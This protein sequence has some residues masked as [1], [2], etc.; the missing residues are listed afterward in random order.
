MSMHFPPAV[1]PDGS[2]DRR[3]K[4]VVLGMDGV[5]GK[6]SLCRRLLTGKFA[7]P[8][9]PDSCWDPSNPGYRPCGAEEPADV[10]VENSGGEHHPDSQPWTVKLCDTA[11]G[12]DYWKL[13]PTTVYPGTHC[14]ILCFS[15]Q[16]RYDSLK[17]VMREGPTPSE[18]RG[19]SCGWASEVRHLYPASRGFKIPLILV[20]TKLDL[21]EAAAAA[22]ASSQRSSHTVGCCGAPPSD[23]APD[24]VTH[25]EGLVAS[26]RLGA[27]QYV[28]VS[29]LTKQGLPELLGHVV[30]LCAA[31]PA[32]HMHL[33]GRA[34][35]PVWTEAEGDQFFAP[36]AAVGGKKR[37]AEQ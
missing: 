11:G 10:V 9:D 17:S 15:L 35:L 21:R 3:L 12:E 33:R 5:A 4:C 13:R 26:K 32:D 20:G 14:F 18:K 34:N 31:P 25:E 23:N 2:Q 30:R 19:R 27:A 1:G 6:S 24:F 7:D 37:C 22:S 28:E 36:G 16:K 29:S 8:S